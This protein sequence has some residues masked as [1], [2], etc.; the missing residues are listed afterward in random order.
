MSMPSAHRCACGECRVENKSHRGIIEEQLKRNL[1]FKF[2]IDVNSSICFFSFDKFPT[3]RLDVLC[4][5]QASGSHDAM[6]ITVRQSEAMQK[7]KPYRTCSTYYHIFVKHF[8]FIYGCK[9][10]SYLLP[11]TQYVWTDARLYIVSSPSRIRS[12]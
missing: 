4:N 8:L 10:L 6:F 3:D 7:T 2:G 1:V 12:I 9:K 5:K 11:N